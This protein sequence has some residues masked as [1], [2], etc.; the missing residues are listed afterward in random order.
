[1]KRSV[2]IAV[3]VLVVLALAFVSMSFF[4]HTRQDAYEPH[5]QTPTP[6]AAEAAPPQMGQEAPAPEATPSQVKSAS[7]EKHGQST[8]QIGERTKYKPYDFEADA[9]SSASSTSP[10]TKVLLI[11]EITIVGDESIERYP[12]IEAPDTVAVGQEIAVQVS[13]TTEQLAP[14]TKII[15][16]A[17]HDGKLQLEGIPGEDHF[18]LT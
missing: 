8:P 16:G 18:T 10:N 4:V 14:E 7:A 12:N 13:L 15:S 17:Q 5:P 3:A 6:P 9:Q 2:A 1:M 11:G